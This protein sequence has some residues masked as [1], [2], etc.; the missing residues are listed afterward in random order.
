MEQITIDM[1]VLKNKDMSG[2]DISPLLEAINPPTE[3]CEKV[4]RG[5]IIKHIVIGGA[6]AAGFISYGVLQEA[7]KQHMW[8]LKNIQTFYGCSVG[9]YLVVALSL[10][11]DWRTLDDS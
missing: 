2:I 7:E 10:D 11:Y 8:K 4:K 5:P 3:P 1:D 9:A 6:G